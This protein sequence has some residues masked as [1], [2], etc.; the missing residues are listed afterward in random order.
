MEKPASGGEANQLWLEC[1]TVCTPLTQGWRRN[2]NWPG[3]LQT[4]LDNVSPAGKIGNIYR[5]TGAANDM[6]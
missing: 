5:W 1:G 2:Q 4:T 6:S 3:Q